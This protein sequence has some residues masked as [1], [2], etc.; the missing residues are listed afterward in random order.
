M[1]SGND[2]CGDTRRSLSTP[3]LNERLNVNAQS[4]A[5]PVSAQPPQLPV[6]A[7]KPL[8]EG[9]VREVRVRYGRSR[10]PVDKGTKIEMPIDI[11]EAFRDLADEPVEVFRVGF[12]DSGN[13]LLAYE[14][15]SRGILTSTLAHP[16]E[17]FYSAVHLRAAAIVCAHNHPGSSPAP[18][19]A[20]MELTGRLVNAGEILGIRLLDHVIITPDDYYS[21]QEYRQL[22]RW[23]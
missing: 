15:I 5:Y 4:L 13:N 1:E 12:L 14:D 17:V 19:A 18:S 21:F 6:P 16:R 11:A 22:G 9:R 23:G 8:P 2:G 20:D 10:V 7:W 3:N